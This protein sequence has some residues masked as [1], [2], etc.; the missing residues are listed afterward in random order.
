MVRRGDPSVAIAD[1]WAVLLSVLLCS[2]LLA[3]SGYGL[4]RDMVF[5]PRQPLSADAIGMGT[6]PAR[7]VPV[8]GL[9]GVL[10]SVLDG[11]WVGRTVITAVLVVA[12]CGMHRLLVATSLPARLVMA[13]LAVWN[14][15]VV[16]R[17]ALGQWALLAGYAALPW[18]VVALR[19]WASTR[20]L[21]A[22]VLASIVAWLGLASITPTGGL[23]AAVSVLVLGAGR[24]PAHNAALAAAALL[25]Q[26]PW[27]LPSLLSVARATSDPAAVAA[28]AA[29][30]ERPGGAVLSLLG[31]GGIW[32][33][34]STPGSRGGPLGYLS[35]AVVAACLVL[36]ARRLAMPRLA[37]LAAAGFAL[38]ALSSSGGGD[39]VR[40]AVRTLPGAGLLRD[41]QKWVLPFV[42][43][44]IACVGVTV[45]RGVAALG[46]RVRE[47]AVLSAVLAAAAPLLLLPD[48]ASTVQRTLS[49]VTYPP[50]FA[51]VARLVAGQGAVV[52]LP[53]QSNRLFRWGRP[54]SVADPASRWFDTTVITSAELVVGRTH[55]SGDDRRAAEVGRALHSGV[56]TGSAL[57]AAGVTWALLYLD[58]PGARGVATDG[59][60]AAYRGRDLALYRVEAT[61]PAE[62]A[63][64]PSRAATLAVAAVDVGVLVVV[65]T[66]ALWTA[67]RRVRRR[68]QPPQ[69]AKLR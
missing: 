36:G 48:A 38:A 4:A 24:R 16:E 5:T 13:G 45:Q 25:T 46:G 37:A 35:T 26:L 41:G 50:D 60:R 58:Q 49:P 17:L 28:F 68:A 67:L 42:V 51:A 39:V 7:A 69:T 11:T 31:F 10:T 65:L 62:P 64:T 30:A 20:A 9:L 44:A 33:A 57:A 6:A 32:D 23:I 61:V 29:R 53:F 27:L 52:T 55:L 1:L 3:G 40:W 8:D 34:G 43:F 63:R 56:A 18:L 66:A 47:V 2:H 21:S 22:P 12:G 15:F 19:R 59:M 14:P 54:V